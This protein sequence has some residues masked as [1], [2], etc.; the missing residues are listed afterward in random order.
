MAGAA[1]VLVAVSRAG[2]P[3][4]IKPQGACTAAI[5]GTIENYVRQF[6]TPDTTDIYFDLSGADTIDSTFAG[7]LLSLALKKEDSHL[8]DIHLVCPSPRVL[9][10]LKILHVV[11]LF[12]ICDAQPDPPTEWAELPTE[13]ADP[14][15]FVDRVIQAHEELI[16]ADERNLPAFGRVVE[17]FRAEQMRRRDSEAEH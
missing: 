14:C 17:G 1:Q 2:G 15:Y 12:D 6:R 3:V 13:S 10:T 7:V 9:N 4:T 8:P 16:D 11:S 5:C